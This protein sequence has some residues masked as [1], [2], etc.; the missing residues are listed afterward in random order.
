MNTVLAAV[1]VVACVDNSAAGMSLADVMDGSERS[2]LVRREAR[3][4]VERTVQEHRQGGVPSA[5]WPPQKFSSAECDDVFPHGLMNKS[6]CQQANA[7]YYQVDSREMCEYA[8][9]ANGYLIERP[10]DYTEDIFEIP[11]SSFKDHPEG[12]FAFPCRSVPGS[13]C[14]YFNDVGDESSVTAPQG[15]AVCVEYK[16][17]DGTIATTG[18]VGVTCDTGYD[19][20]MDEDLCLEVAECLGQ[21][22]GHEFRIA[23]HNMSMYHDFPV[24]C[25]K[26]PSIVN[27][28]GKN[29][30]FFNP[31]QNITGEPLP[32]R[33]KG[34]PICDVITRRH[35]TEAKVEAKKLL[36]ATT[37]APST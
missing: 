5:S 19:T 35:E 4:E 6:S 29:C 24:G 14:Y 12:C 32:T 10:P 20:I 26:H 11:S 16:Y 13:K 23:E 3:D 8:A 33:A 34:T 31:R 28:D 36:A 17:T 30:V 18:D 22:T 7:T 37:A 25:F 27:N 2:R 21:C 15:E 9:Q 1:F